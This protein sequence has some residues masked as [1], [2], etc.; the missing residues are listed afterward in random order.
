M[1]GKL[2]ITLLLVV[3][4]AASSLAQPD[5]PITTA[6]IEF[7]EAG[8]LNEAK[9][10]IDEAIS[11]NEGKEAHT[12]YAHGFIYKEIFK[13]LDNENKYSPNREKAI[14]SI[15]KCLNIDKT[16]QY[17]QPC[18]DVL[19][20]LMGTYYEDAMNGAK[21]LSLENRDEPDKFFTKYRQTLQL[22]NPGTKQGVKEMD[23]YKLMGS[24]YAKI[25]EKNPQ[26]GQAYVDASIVYFKDALLVDSMDYDSNYNLAIAYFNQGVRK[27]RSIG[28]ETE[29][30]EIIRIQESAIILFK[31]SL[32]YMLRAD[33]I[34]PGRKESLK[35]LHFIF[36]GL[37]NEDRANYY[38]G[39][40]ER[41]FG[42]G[43]K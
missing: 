43:L 41:L 29:I 5:L 11:T 36:R 13:Q 16:G 2:Y 42:S 19:D 34:Q 17:V 25:Y 30:S 24:S 31:A 33:E 8:K 14:D 35:G 20:W 26:Q 10:K 27:I 3:F 9:I 18:K 22:T 38:K 7:L 12:W 23:Y 1:K 15:T 32:P 21:F 39:E 28:I 40:L 37:N 4:G 6:A